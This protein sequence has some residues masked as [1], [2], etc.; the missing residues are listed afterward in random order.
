[1][2]I[3]S[4]SL[5]KV[6]DEAIV[7]PCSGTKITDGKRPAI[8]VHLAFLADALRWESSMKL[9]TVLTQHGLGAADQLKCGGKK[10]RAWLLSDA[11]TR[12]IAENSTT[13]TEGA[14]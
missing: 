4:R 3:E 11:V 2:S 14:G 8:A 6:G 10:W 13:D 9:S 1:M 7:L 5:S 12:A